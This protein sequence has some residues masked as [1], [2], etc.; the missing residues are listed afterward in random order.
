MNHG[1][2]GFSFPASSDVWFYDNFT[3]P[4]NSL[5]VGDTPIGG[6]H[7]WTWGRTATSVWGIVNNKAQ[8]INSANEARLNYQVP[9]TSYALEVGVDASTFGSGNG[10]ITFRGLGPQAELVC[11]PNGTNNVSVY[12]YSGTTYTVRYNYTIDATNRSCLWRFEVCPTFFNIYYNGM[13]LCHQLDS[14][15]YTEGRCVAIRSSDNAG[16]YRYTSI[17]LYKYFG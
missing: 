5:V 13:Q 2:Q 3:R 11:M 7:P 4:N 9:C 6:F 10:G 17:G 16:G 15:Y 14:T 12:T 1:M 8:A